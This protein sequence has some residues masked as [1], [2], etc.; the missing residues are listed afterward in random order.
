MMK[1]INWNFIIFTCLLCLIFLNQTLDTISA[2]A[3]ICIC[4]GIF[5]LGIFEKS[6]TC[7]SE[8]KK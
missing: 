6:N 7:K 5:L 1:K 2:V 8:N 4:V 3:I